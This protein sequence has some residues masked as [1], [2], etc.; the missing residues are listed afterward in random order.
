[1]AVLCSGRAGAY[2]PRR[3]PRGFR[4]MTRFGVS[5]GDANLRFAAGNWACLCVFPAN[6]WHTYIFGSPNNSVPITVITGPPDFSLTVCPAKNFC[7]AI[8]SSLLSGD[9]GRK[10]SPVLNVGLALSSRASVA[11]PAALCNGHEG[12][13]LARDACVAPSTARSQTPRSPHTVASR[14]ASPGCMCS[15]LP[16]CEDSHPLVVCSSRDL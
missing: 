11:G 13:G 14:P 8:L 12:T 5:S 9:A 7:S 15:R 6:H 16:P 2:R 10:V 4:A 1:M 3:I